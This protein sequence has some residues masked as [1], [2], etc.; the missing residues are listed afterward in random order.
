MKTYRLIK[1]YPGSPKLG[2]IRNRQ[3]TSHSLYEVCKEQPEFWEEVKDKNPLNLEV[4]KEY[5]LQYVHC[6][7]KPKRVKITRFTQDGYPWKEGVNCDTN[8]IVSPDCWK[9]IKEVVEKDY[10]ILSFRLCGSKYYTQLEYDGKDMYCNGSFSYTENEALISGWIIHSV[11]RLSDGEVF[12]VGDN[13]NAGVIKQFSLYENT[14]QLKVDGLIFLDDCL[15]KKSLFKS[16]EANEEHILMNKP[17]LSINDLLK[18]RGFISEWFI[19]D[20][21]EVIKSK[22]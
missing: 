4:G 1:E 7:S 18:T 14:L 17:C 2:T 13:T 20:L 15:C 22:L 19:N 12:S 10:Q 6:N 3:T 9:L 5:L 8:G 21:K 16:E 11:K